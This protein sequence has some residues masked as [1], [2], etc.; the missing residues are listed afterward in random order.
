MIVRP[1]TLE[2]TARDSRGAETYAAGTRPNGGTSILQIAEGVV[3]FNLQQ[4]EGPPE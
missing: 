3:I 1:D 2:D 4:L